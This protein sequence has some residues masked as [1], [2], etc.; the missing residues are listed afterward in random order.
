MSPQLLAPQGGPPLLPEWLATPSFA[1]QRVTGVGSLPCRPLSL[2]GGNLCKRL[3]PDDPWECPQQRQ[4]RASLRPQ[5]CLGRRP[6]PRPRQPK[7]GAPQAP[8]QAH[9][10]LCRGLPSSPP[11]G[12]RRAPRRCATPEAV[13]PRQAAPEGRGQFPGSLSQSQALT[14]GHSVTQCVSEERDASDP[15]VGATFSRATPRPQ[16]PS[17][18]PTCGSA[19]GGPPPTPLFPH[20]PGGG[21]AAWSAHGAG[22][23][24]T[25]AAL[26]APRGSR[27]R[28]AGL[29][30]LPRPGSAS[31]PSARSPRSALRSGL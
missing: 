25:R 30:A 24:P 26:E 21:G 9:R 22:A 8:R 7:P 2:C 5:S 17:P 28:G 15:A 14:S 4:P 11:P 27:T 1:Q 19:K 13:H 3:L 29:A 23:Y 12:P 31:R 10:P 16:S 18:L 6:L 20:Q